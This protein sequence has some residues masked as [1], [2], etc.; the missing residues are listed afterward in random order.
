LSWLI[1]KAIRPSEIAKK[2][3]KK[4]AITAAKQIKNEEMLQAL[5]VLLVEAKKALSNNNHE[6]VVKILHD[7]IL[8]DLNLRRIIDGQIMDK[9]TVSQK[10][11]ENSIELQSY[12]NV[13]RSNLLMAIIETLVAGYDIVEKNIIHDTKYSLEYYDYIIRLHSYYVQSLDFLTLEGA[14]A[15]ENKV[16]QESIIVFN[17]VFNSATERIQNIMRLAG[18]EIA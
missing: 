14:D 13:I 16:Y 5:D 8:H 12:Y 11:L 15:Q 1:P 10:T 17:E 3:A 6:M 7:L 4:K 9:A 18:L 2:R